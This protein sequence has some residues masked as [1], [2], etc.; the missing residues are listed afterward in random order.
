MRTNSRK[1]ITGRALKVGVVCGRPTREL[2]D[3]EWMLC[4]VR[5]MSRLLCRMIRR[6]AKALAAYSRSIDA[7][8]Q[9][10]AAANDRAALSQAENNVLD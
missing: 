8:L 5:R 9:R 3:A 1:Q 2:H 4:F 7:L 10:I 6:A